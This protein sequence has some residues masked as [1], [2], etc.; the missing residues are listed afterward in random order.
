MFCS[1]CGKK[2]VKGSTFCEKCG[3][4]L[5]DNSKNE[6][7]RKPMSKK[8]KVLLFFVILIVVSLSS[9][10][11]ILKNMTD[12]KN[13]AKKYFLAVTS[14]NADEIYDFLEL[15]SSPFTSKKIFKALVDKEKKN[16]KK[17][18]NY[19]INDAEISDDKMSAT[20]KIKYYLDNEDD[21]DYLTVKLVKAKENKWLIFN[22]WRV[23]INN[24]GTIT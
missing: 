14:Y 15:N 18:I 6:K 20:V 21:A 10:Y 3:A 11:L 22:N 17:I 2:N 1:E 16:D 13:V 5:E 4:K 7:I 12:P 24:I 23:S 9:A 19:N 8:Q